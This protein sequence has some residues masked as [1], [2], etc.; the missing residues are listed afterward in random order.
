MSIPVRLRLHPE[1]F[2]RKRGAHKCSLREIKV[3]SAQL[4][5]FLGPAV[6]WVAVVSSCFVF[7]HDSRA[8]CVTA[9]SGLVS[10][11][12]GEGN[13]IDTVSTNNGTLSGGAS[14]ASGEIGQGFSY[15][16]TGEVAVPGTPSLNVTTFTLEAWVNPSVLDGNME[17]IL[18]KEN[19]PAFNESDVSYELAIRGTADPGAGSIPVGQLAFF[20]GGINGLQGEYGSWVG[21]GS[22]IPTN[23]W[24]HCALT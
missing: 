12:R 3:R 4:I 7:S 5:P 15:D 22:T 2:M 6:C 14:F 11:W 23:Q 10:W 13:A 20:V 16:G 24:S 19:S 21:G 8:A 17:I 18:N 1:G 9:P